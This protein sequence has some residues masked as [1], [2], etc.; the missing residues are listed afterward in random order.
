MLQR[1]FLTATPVPDNPAKYLDDLKREDGGTFGK[2]GDTLQQT[3]ADAYG[4]L[5]VVGI[6]LIGLCLVVAFICFGILKDNSTI[7]ENKQWIMRLL[8]AV[9]GVSCVITIIGIAAGIGESIN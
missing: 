1:I 8:I 4:M 6:G 3:I 5:T 2:L 7:K 9:I